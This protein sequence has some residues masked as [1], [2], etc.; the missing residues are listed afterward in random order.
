MSDNQKILKVGYA[1]TANEEQ[2]PSIK[3][4]GKWLNDLGFNVNNKY[5]VR[6]EKGKLILEII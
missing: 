4:Q 5:A 6:Y 2:I 1:W 3:I